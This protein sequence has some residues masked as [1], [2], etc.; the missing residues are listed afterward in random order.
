MI[1]SIAH[2]QGVCNEKSQVVWLLASCLLAYDVFF[3][4]CLVFVVSYN[5]DA[6]QYCLHGRG[7]TSH[8]SLELLGGVDL[9]VAGLRRKLSVV[10]ESAHETEGVASCGAGHYFSIPIKHKS[11]EK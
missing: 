4:V 6:F 8:N 7:A 2:R 10:S 3:D 11:F 5:A 1:V 9:F